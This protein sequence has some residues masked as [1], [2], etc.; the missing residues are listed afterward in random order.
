M[1]LFLTINNYTD[2]QTVI[3]QNCVGNEVQLLWKKALEQLY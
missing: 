2:F 1:F 3:H